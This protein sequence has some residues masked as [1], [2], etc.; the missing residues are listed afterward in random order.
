MSSLTGQHAAQCLLAVPGDVGDAPVLLE[1][2]E[3]EDDGLRL[4]QV[5]ERDGGARLAR[6]GVADRNL[7]ALDLPILRIDE[8]IGAELADLAARLSAVLDDE[9]RKGGR[10]IA[11]H[12]RVT[13]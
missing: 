8:R 7:D 13:S 11:S 5:L 4:A 1:L 2:D 12:R 10:E 9:S 3:V 6:G